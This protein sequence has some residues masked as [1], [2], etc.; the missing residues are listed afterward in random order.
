[1]VL[2]NVSGEKLLIPWH[3][4]VPDKTE[5]GTYAGW[6]MKNGVMELI[7]LWNEVS[8][9]SRPWR[10]N[11]LGF[12]RVPPGNFVLFLRS[13][14][15]NQGLP[16]DSPAKNWPSFNRVLSPCHGFCA[17]IQIVILWPEY[18]RK[19]SIYNN[20]PW[21]LCIFLQASHSSFFYFFF[22]FFNF[23]CFST[24]GQDLILKRACPPSWTDMMST[25]DKNK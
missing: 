20:F 21:F 22:F 2:W 14:F 16:S 1:M 8:S 23:Y 17:D 3:H 12:C 4:V 9:P 15:A 10:K 24:Q 25:L 13:G 6:R 5:W 19:H 7:R 11:I 18:S